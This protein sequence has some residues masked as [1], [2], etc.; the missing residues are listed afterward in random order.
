MGERK[1]LNKHIPP[2]FDPKLIPRGKRPKGELVPVRMMLP[3][4]IQCETCSSFLYRGRKFNSK[5]EP[6]RGSGGKYLGIQK[7]RF[8]VKCTACS[9]PLTFITDPKN[10]EYEMESGGI[11]TYEIHRDK[12]LIEHSFLQEKTTE[13]KDDPIKALENRVF[14]STR[15][16]EEIKNLE[17]IIA[18]NKKKSKMTSWTGSESGEIIQ[19]ASLLSNKLSVNE[20][21]SE[22]FNKDDEKL[23]KTINF[24]HKDNTSS[25]NGPVLLDNAEMIEF[26][27]KRLEDNHLQRK[28]RLLGDKYLHKSDYDSKLTIKTK[29][30][31]IF[32][33]KKRFNSTSCNKINGIVHLFEVYD[34]ESN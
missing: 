26:N 8:I 10:A 16:M 9:R 13:E 22:I 21:D 18:L 28:V 14:A 29:K 6:V 17:Q 34:S 25:I 32:S 23:I 24:Q 27:K 1:V 31:A 11:R 7:Y 12:D 5:K 2:D 3:F 4:T 20:M 19:N 30:R 15:E 33:E